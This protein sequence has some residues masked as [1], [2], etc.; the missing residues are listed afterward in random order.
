MENRAEHLDVV[1]RAVR[2]PQPSSST[3]LP[4]MSGADSTSREAIAILAELASDVTGA[5]QHAADAMAGRL[6]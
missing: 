3:M 1:F 2:L 6:A 5:V 4:R